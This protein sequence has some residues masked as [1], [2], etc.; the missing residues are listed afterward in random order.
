VLRAASFAELPGWE[1]DQHAAVLP[2]LL[3]SCDRW[4]GLAPPAAVGGAVD[5]GA[6][7]DWLPLC[8][9]AAALPPGDGAALRSLLERELRPWKVAN[10]E[11]SVGL[12]TG[13]YEPT[14]RGSRRPDE[15]FAVPLH[16]RPPELVSVELGRFR[17]ELAGTRLAGRVE[18][19]A[20][21]PYHD[22]GAIEE[23]ALTGRGLELVWVDDAID[24]FFL[25]IQ[26]SGRVELVEGGVLRVGYAGQNG[27][28]YYAIGREL[29]ARGALT[30]EQ[31]SMQSIAAWLRAHPAEAVE[32][33][34]RNA[35]YVFFREL[36]EDG[37]LGASGVV[38][39]P[40][41][42]LAVDP[43]F[44]AF[45]TLLWLDTTL[46]ETGEAPADGEPATRTEEPSPPRPLRRLVV[47]QDTGGAIRGPVRGDVFFGPGAEAAELA[48]HMRQPGRLWVLL[49]RQVEPAAHAGDQQGE[50]R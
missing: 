2:A 40:G 46:P 19:G 48:G 38:L 3:R 27:F 25:H 7:G 11:E 42:S 15:R 33:M 8:A 24:A 6:V 10:H 36:A 32:V 28:P 29:V 5:T 21:V 26:G 45:G 35:S 18:D 41:R 44:H 34:R 22:R 1:H 50:E 9:A 4:G 13:Y 14:L 31:V 47:A 23:G 20:L 39:T 37:P 49:P 30:L 43:R 16:L 12:F 17:P